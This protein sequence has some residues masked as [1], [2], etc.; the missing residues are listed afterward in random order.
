MGHLVSKYVNNV[1]GWA[2]V[3]IPIQR[4]PSHTVS[5]TRCGD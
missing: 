3:Y 5:M 4:A 2:I 1:G